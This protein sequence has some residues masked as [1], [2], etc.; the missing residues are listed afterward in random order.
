MI[1]KNRMI[2]NSIIINRN[3]M[4]NNSRIIKIYQ[5]QIILKIKAQK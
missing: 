3:K 5:I 1:N 2:N 4:I